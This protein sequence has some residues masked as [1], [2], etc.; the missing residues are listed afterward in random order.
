MDGFPLR[1]REAE[2]PG[3]GQNKGQ[4]NVPLRWGARLPS[5]LGVESSKNVQRSTERFGRG[6]AR[7]LLRRARELH[8]LEQ[9]IDHLLHRDAFGFGA[10]VDQD[11]VPESGMGERLNVLWS[12]MRASLQEGTHLGAQDQELT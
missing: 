11:A 10:V 9:S 12:D 5:K 6:F 8:R 2:G 4:N 7:F 3:E 1:L